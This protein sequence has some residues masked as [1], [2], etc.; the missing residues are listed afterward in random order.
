M[1]MHHNLITIGHPGWWKTYELVTQNYW[2][3][4]ILTF[5]KE[6]VNGCAVCQT[7]KKLP[8]TT[9][10]LRPN[11]VPQDMWQEVTMDFI[12]NLPQS[13]G[14]DSLLVTVDHFSKA[15]ILIP[16]NKTI[17]ADETAQLFL[18]HVWKRTGLLEQIIS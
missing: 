10:P 2:W 7:T 13:Q 8:Q 9:V 4:G 17:M 16:C 5:V 15:T 11:P 14:Y 6:Y 12:I 18:N 1:K 3:P